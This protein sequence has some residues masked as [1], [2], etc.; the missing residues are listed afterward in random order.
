MEGNLIT[1]KKITKIFW[2]LDLVSE[3]V[4]KR[5]YIIDKKIS[6]LGIKRMGYNVVH[7]ECSKNLEFLEVEPLVNRIGEKP[8]GR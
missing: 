6:L 2:I 8:L 7:S 5:N 1:N 3:I 4:V